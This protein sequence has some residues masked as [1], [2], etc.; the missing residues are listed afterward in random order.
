LL[1]GGSTFLA[2]LLIGL[3][4]T[5]LLLLLTSEPRGLPIALLPL[6]TESPIRVHVAGAVQFPGVY[7]LPQG[8]IVQEVVDAAGGALAEAELGAVNL[9][10]KL[11]DGT[12][13]F[14]PKA[15][16]AIPTPFLLLDPS[17]SSTQVRINQATAKELELLPGIGPVLAATIIEHREAN[18]PFQTA[19][20]M[21][22]VVGIGPAKLAAIRDLII[23]P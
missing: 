18:G 14:I 23:L 5:G 22:Q 1:K 6:P 2:G 20:D 12:Q 10:A 3:L 16:E 4:S 21:L 13:V 15:G 19:E 7:A 8:S 9:A 11:S 17:S